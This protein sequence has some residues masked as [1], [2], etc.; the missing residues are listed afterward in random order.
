VAEAV[1]DFAVG[2]TFNS[3]PKEVV[4]HTKLH[5]MNIIGLCI[6]ASGLEAGKIAAEVV[7]Q[8]QGRGEATVIASGYLAP[9]PNAAL[10]NGTMAHVLDFD[11]T[12]N[13]SFV[14]VGPPVIP[15]ALA[16]GEREGKDGK[17]LI[18]AVSAGMETAIRVGMAAPGQLP[19]QG[20]HA[21]SICGTFGALVASSK[22]LN[23]KTSQIVNGL[24]IC[25]SQASGIYEFFS[26]GSW[27]KQFHPGWA[28]HSGIIA[29]L[30]AQKG[31]TGPRTVFEGRF[32]VYKTHLRQI[33]LAIERA[34]EGLGEL[35]EIAKIAYK[36]YPC[37]V[38]LH[39]FLY[40]ASRLKRNHGINGDDIAEVRCEVPSG[41][42]PLVC[43]P[44]EAKATPRTAYDGKFSLPFTVAAM[45]V[46][47]KV[48]VNTFTEDKIKDRKILELAKGVKYVADP[49]TEYPKR[50][51]GHV[52]VK[53]KSGITHEFKVETNPGGPEIPMTKEEHISKFKS[54]AS[55]VLGEEAIRDML[56]KL[57]NLERVKNIQ[58]L[59]R[60][61]RRDL[62]HSGCELKLV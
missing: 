17:A 54:N 15:V 62:Y 4:E 11:D 44:V 49:N 38:V 27:V 50:I 30:M 32:G 33:S 24:G 8:W 31:M 26:D 23:L 21:T 36:P 20:F 13:E 37:G 41:M 25:G 5:I 18:T 39:P 2:L 57:E 10:V 53:M 60:L 47:G 16:M 9:A 58:E 7:R 3:L 14:H 42:V 19:K 34:V 43:E 55:I 1:S 51:P 6:A 46:D 52:S 28:A 61:C 22:I 12:H 45:L 59:M 40:C 29:S 35:W 48:N 56:D